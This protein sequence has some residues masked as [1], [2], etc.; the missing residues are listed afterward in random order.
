M[1]VHPAVRGVPQ[2]YLFGARLWGGAWIA[3]TVASVCL[4]T[5]LLLVSY[6]LLTQRSCRCADSS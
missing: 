4:T 5:S 3:A 6:R 1:R 2:T